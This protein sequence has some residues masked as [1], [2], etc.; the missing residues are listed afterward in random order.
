MSTEIT[1]I[2]V[3]GIDIDVIKKDIKNMHLSV[4]PPTGRV[5]I[6]SPA[7]MDTDSIR[8]FAV[9]KLGWIKR[10]M[11][12][13][14]SQDRQPPRE[15]IQGESHYFQGQRY[16]MNIIEDEAPPKVEIRNKKYLDLYVRPGS[17]KEKRENVVREWYRDE[18]KKLIPPLI[19][20]WEERL[21]ITVQEWGIRQMKTKWGSCNNDE[22]RIWL[23]LEL[24]KKSKQCVEYV[25]VHEMVHLQERLH[26]ERFQSL[27]EKYMPK[28]KVYKEELNEVIY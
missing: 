15:F 24:A 8:L 12:N 3:S 27:L 28:W 20:K 9:S 10:H 13:I 4:H 25:L 16:L 14:Q 22:Q 6:S 2:T 21:G 1:Q 7:R 17:D 26:T 11:N 5:R 19:E 18:L 23:N